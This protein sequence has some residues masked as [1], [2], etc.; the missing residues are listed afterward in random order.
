MLCGALLVCL[1]P[2]TSDGAKRRP[3][4]L[5]LG[6]AGHHS[7]PGSVRTP[8]LLPPSSWCAR[9]DRRTAIRC[10]A[11]S[12]RFISPTEN[13]LTGTHPNCLYNFKAGL[14]VED[15]RVRRRI[16]PN[17]RGRSSNNR[18][19]V[20]SLPQRHWCDD[21]PESVHLQPAPATAT[22]LPNRSAI[23]EQRSVLEQNEM[24]RMESALTS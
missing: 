12:S 18:R 1:T 21:V 4:R 3:L 15:C 13:V 20:T 19:P 24:R 9:S 2:G 22:V 5:L 16:G 11:I 6:G 8:P 23:A 7:S 14:R 17:M 10:G